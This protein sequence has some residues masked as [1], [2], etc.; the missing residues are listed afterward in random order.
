MFW[1]I[2]P[3]TTRWEAIRVR[4][5]VYKLI[6]QFEI[7]YTISM[8][9]SELT[10]PRATGVDTAGNVYVTGDA[11]S[12]DFPL[13]RSAQSKRGNPFLTKLNPQ[14]DITFSTYFGGSDRSSW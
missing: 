4:A 7:V 11:G 10:F 2:R 12:S 3:P 6:P 1:L 5:I 13:V 9:S 8:G 14:G